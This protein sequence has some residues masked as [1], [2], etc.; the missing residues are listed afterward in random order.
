MFG[1]QSALWVMHS[2]AEW[3]K[4]GRWA[5]FTYVCRNIFAHPTKEMHMPN[6]CQIQYQ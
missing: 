2:A 4:K 6:N 5:S 3:G 1:V